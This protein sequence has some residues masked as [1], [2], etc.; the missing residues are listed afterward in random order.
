[1]LSFNAGRISPKLPTAIS[2]H[3]LGSSILGRVRSAHTTSV[4]EA[5][6]PMLPTG[7][8]IAA[9]NGVTR[10]ALADKSFACRATIRRVG[11]RT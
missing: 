10:A 7:S 3:D 9:D 4:G 5:T 2:G 8:S 6:F 11:V 1:M